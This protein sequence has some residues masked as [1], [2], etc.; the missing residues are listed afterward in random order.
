MRI[1]RQQ[2]NGGSTVLISLVACLIAGIVLASYLTL[3]SNRFS[4]SMRSKCWNEALPVLEA[5]IEEG[6]THL[7]DDSRPGANGWTKGTISGQ[8]VYTKQRNFSDASYY[9]VTIYNVMTTNPVIYASGFVPSPVDTKSGYISRMVKVTTFKPDVFNNAIA[10]SGPISMGGTAMVD[11]YNSCAGP[12]S[13]SNSLGTNGSIATDGSISLGNAQ[14]YGTVTS[15]PSGTVTVG[16]RGGAGDD[17][18]NASNPGE[19]EPGWSN[20]TMNVSFPSNSPPS[21]GPFLAPP[22]VAV[23]SSNIT[24]LTGSTNQM[25]SLSLSSASQP[26]IVT[27][28]S[29][30][31]VTG[32][33]SI[34]GNGYIEIMP[35]GSLTLI[36]GGS[37]SFGGGGI[38]NGTGEP[39]DMS[40]VGLCSATSISYGGGADFVGT[41]NAPQASL[42]LAGTANVYGAAIVNTFNCTGTSEFHYDSC[43]DA[44]NNLVVTSWVE[45][46]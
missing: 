45:M 13:V 14:V 11:S 43:L 6:M 21:G 7:H 25:S 41:I 17:S 12:Y 30:L 1:S 46:L 31:Y 4:T 40:L 28:P 44:T 24:M 22:V 32:N 33:I 9:Y 26:M 18:W 10:A 2:R 36:M 29:V 42:T 37:A 19:I 15:G 39:A 8:T 3:V 16:P 34:T 27:A 35:G 38:V 20:D 23:G 5:G